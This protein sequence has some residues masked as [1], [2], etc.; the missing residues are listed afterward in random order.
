MDIT[1]IPALAAFA[2][3]T[4]ITP[5]PNTLMLMASGANFGLRRTLPH[6]LGVGIGFTVMLAGV[7]LGVTELLAAVPALG[8]AL[9]LACAAFLLRLAWR[10]AHAGPADRA[11]RA[12]PMS[13]LEAAAFQWINPKGW[14][15]ALAAVGVYAPGEGAAA[16]LV[17]AAVFG[18]VN[19]PSVG[20]WAAAGRML[21]RWLAPPRR[22]RA[23]NR[24]MALLLL[25]TLPP[26]LLA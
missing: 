16:V 19:L 8:L 17:T 14:A 23:F 12:R 13:F 20:A 7:G 18:A 4:S 1:L 6:M 21:D 3:A 24:T 22:R 2:F 25:A 15:M 10:V 11:A 26:A 5:G 9:K